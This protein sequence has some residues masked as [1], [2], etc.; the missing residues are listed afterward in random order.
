[1][2]CL[3]ILRARIA[4]LMYSSSLKPLQMIGR[5]GAVGHGQHGQEFRLGARFEAEAERLAEVED[6]LHDVALLVDL[7]GV[8]AAVF[9][10]VAVLGDGGL[11]R[12]RGSRRRD[13]EG[14]R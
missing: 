4:I 11:E 13:G 12:P 3:P 7:D 1:M 10:L 8:D 9:A 14:Y 6:L 2:I 5:V